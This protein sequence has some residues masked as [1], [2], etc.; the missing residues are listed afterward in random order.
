MRFCSIAFIASTGSAFTPSNSF[1]RIHNGFA[2]KTQQQPRLRLL[3]DPTMANE[4]TNLVTESAFSSSSITTSN[5]ID[6]LVSSVGG[7]VLIAGVGA[8]VYS[9]ALEEKHM[10]LQKQLNEFFDKET[11]DDFAVPVAEEPA[12][13]VEFKENVKESIESAEE[14]VA[15]K[16][17]EATEAVAEVVEEVVEEMGDI[18]GEVL[19][20]LPP[21]VPVTSEK[22]LK[23]TEK[24]IAE[25]KAKGVEE[26]KEKMR[27]NESAL[28]P[29]TPSEPV[30]EPKKE[31]AKTE[32]DAGTKKKVAQGVTL[33][34]A[35]VGVAVAR[36]VI[37]AWLGRGLF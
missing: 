24:A 13:V 4:M 2:H 37:K 35:A 11:A 3:P 18:T 33:I 5:F 36:N 21:P 27:F 34:V 1:T 17:E 30:A 26:T 14:A 28:S 29:P 12:K 25:V 7:L 8:G 23:E 20:T 31:V 10:E 6:S 9:T 15:G 19:A 32:K 16:V 22:V